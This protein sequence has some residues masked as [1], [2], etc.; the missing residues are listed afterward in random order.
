M[1]DPA[2]PIAS[3]WMSS[4]PLDRRFVRVEESGGRDGRPRVLTHSPRSSPR[5][6]SRNSLRNTND[7]PACNRSPPAAA[8]G[9]IRIIR[10]SQ[11]PAAQLFKDAAKAHQ[12]RARDRSRR[13]HG[14]S[15]GLTRAHRH[16]TQALL[17]GLRRRA[18]G[19]VAALTRWLLVPSLAIVL[20]SGLLAIAANRTY[21]NAGWAWV[22]ALLGLGMFE[23]TLISM[24]S[25]A[26]RAAEL[27]ALAASGHGDA[28]Q[29]ASVLHSEWGNSMAAARGGSGQHPARRV[30]AAAGSADGA[31]V[32]K[33]RLGT[34]MFL[35]FFIWG[36]WF[37]TMGSFLAA[38]LG[39]TGA[40]SALAYST[41]S[42]GA[43]VAPFVIG[44]I[45]DRYVNAERLLG[46]IHCRS[47]H[48]CTGSGNHRDSRISIPTCCRT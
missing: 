4:G 30:A 27:S 34:M 9:N 28:A 3:F 10:H 47:R 42:W 41:Q 29:L 13:S 25:G 15:R 32:M 23:G 38:N 48:Y 45:A 35:E 46:V 33:L 1:V 26:R 11:A 5:T 14:I 44:L 22:K 40:Q 19:N 24:D 43:I 8:P 6:R 2:P 31:D 21:A 20:I 16:C 17:G 12:D 7:P 36:G 37:V 18:A 39:A